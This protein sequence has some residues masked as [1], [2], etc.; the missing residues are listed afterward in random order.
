MRNPRD[1][2]DLCAVQGWQREERTTPVNGGRCRPAERGTETS[3]GGW[4]MEGV[5]NVQV[6][7]ASRQERRFGGGAN[8]RRP[9]Q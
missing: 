2:R 7:G 3:D 9:Q 8:D 1:D 4:R 5:G 6:G